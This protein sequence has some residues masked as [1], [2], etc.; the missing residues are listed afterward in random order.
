VENTEVLKW[1][2]KNRS[3]ETY[4]K[5]GKQAEE[6]IFFFVF[7][8]QKIKILFLTNMMCVPH[9]DLTAVC[10]RVV[11]ATNGGQTLWENSVIVLVQAVAM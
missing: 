8:C 7:T 11:G 6:W 1:N 3:T 2:C 5:Y 9:I 4:L 10:I